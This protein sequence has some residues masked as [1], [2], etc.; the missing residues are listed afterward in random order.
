M[1]I[2]SDKASSGLEYATGDIFWFSSI[3]EGTKARNCLFLPGSFRI[4]ISTSL[5]FTRYFK[6]V[7]F[8]P[9]FSFALLLRNFIALT[10]S[11]AKTSL[12]VKLDIFAV[13]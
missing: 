6:S 4:M 7:N 9:S 2:A 5:T 13:P 11:L 10:Q 12:L 8:A 1:A 3:S